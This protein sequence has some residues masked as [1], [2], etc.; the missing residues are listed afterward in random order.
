MYDLSTGQMLDTYDLL[1]ALSDKW[2]N[3]DTNTQRY[4]AQTIAGTNQ[5]NNFLA[6][7]NNF[8][9]AVEAT[10][11]GLESAGSA[12]RENARYMDGLDAKLNQLKSTFQ[13][14]SNNV[15]ESEVVKALLDLANGAL[16][17]LNTEV[18]QTI[19]QWGLLTGVLTGAITIFGSLAANIAKSV[20][21]LKGL[22]GLS[23]L[24]T[25]IKGGG[26]VAGAAGTA[27]GLGGIIGSIGAIAASAAP[28][29]AAIAAVA[30][31]GYAGY[32]I[33]RK[34]NP[35]VEELK[36]EVGEL[37]TQ[38]E[39]NQARLD[40]INKISYTG[41]TPEIEA[42]RKALEEE[43]A[44]L[45]ENIELKEK[46]IDTR[47]LED[48]IGDERFR[49]GQETY[50]IVLQNEQGN[51]TF[52]TSGTLDAIIEQLT[53][54]GRLGKEWYDV[55]DQMREGTYDFD[56]A[57]LHLKDELGDSIE[58][59]IT[60]ETGF[61]SFEDSLNA[62][63]DQYN[64]YYRQVQAGK[65]LTLEEQ[66][67]FTELTNKIEGAYNALS[68]IDPETEG[69]TDIMK[70]FV[71]IVGKDVLPNLDVLKSQVA[72]F[73]SEGEHANVV[74][75]K[76]L[77]GFTVTADEIAV[78][79][80]MFPD[81]KEKVGE[82]GEAFQN[83]TTSFRESIRAGDEW[84]IKTAENYIKTAEKGIESLEVLLRGNTILA[85]SYAE[86]FGYDSPEY[87]KQRE[88]QVQQLEELMAAR[89]TINALR[90]D[91]YIGS[92]QPDISLVGG[93]EGT[94]SASAQKTRLDLLKEQLEILDH[95]ADLAL[96]NGQDQ[97][98]IVNIY[99]Q[100]QQEIHALA[101]WYR[102]Q[103]YDDTSKEIRELQQLWW[104]YKDEIDDVLDDIV[105]K[106]KEAFEQIKEDAIAGLE[107][108]IDGLEDA[109]S[110][111]DAVISYV[112]N[113]AQ[114]QI[115][116]LNEQRNAI[117]QKYDD[118]I[119]K[120]EDQNDLLE[121][122][123]A[124]EERLDALARA[125]QTQVLVYK[126][127]RYQYLQD[128]D[129]VNQAQLELEEYERDQ[130]LEQEVA[131]LEEL[132]DNELAA[133]D[134]QIAK[135][136]DYKEAWENV[137][138]DYT[139][140]QNA[141]IAEQIVGKDLEKQTWDERWD[142]LNDFVNK[143]AQAMDELKRLQ[144]ELNDWQEKQY[145]DS[146]VNDGAF[147]GASAGGGGGGGGSSLGGAPVK[148]TPGTAWI[149]GVGT[150]PVEIENGKTQTEGLP[151]GTIVSTA[152]GDFEITGGSG[153]NY[154]SKKHASGTINA[155]GGLSL[156]GEKGPELRVL[157]SGDGI[158]PA[159]ITKNLWAWGETTPASVLRAMGDFSKSLAN[160]AYNFTIQNLNLPNVRD[161]QDFANVIT[162]N[163]W[164]QTVQFASK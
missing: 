112:T 56:T 49:V 7:M 133:I 55:V 162:S 72:G 47:S 118:E 97:Q 136:E 73:S 86:S 75:A 121:D 20:A 96:R 98:K 89:E 115:D 19:V 143:Y 110:D 2:Q 62:M 114:D 134:D 88:L 60:Y 113:L 117:S 91:M 28:I 77:G 59:L 138:Q 124:L 54:A 130:A 30:A 68:K 9:H 135:W 151:P 32:K 67:A 128:A 116:A 34:F 36:E 107:D 31:F 71:E 140:N 131:N 45:R 153:G 78:L 108:E 61:M 29:A 43:N 23:S 154:T 52:D 38:L 4:I 92:L 12:A 6:L 70:D 161:P 94:T 40:E 50:N 42:E 58:S 48:V 147:T 127:G 25:L 87:K 27:S 139:D 65:T 109:L 126:D 111:Y 80:K 148:G 149:P 11:V 144:E 137:V 141:L 22:G 46:Q 69:Y 160:K 76:L 99:K 24:V 95:Q 41:I 8:G 84:A 83:Y 93:D 164:I 51:L 100:A 74:L 157:N 120:L 1:S 156:V 63:I 81:L 21:A 102:D 132:R 142:N 155:P 16:Q 14:L 18:G 146:V 35:T 152:G 82:T 10:A 3:L 150:V 26:A 13:D 105:E 125:K 5:L 79:T 103:G 44:A 33:Y 101:E 129:A 37:N 123:I 159:D 163:M 119:A 122:Q 85:R 57:L 104:G 106:N 158:L 17:L 39:E 64:E 90:A 15:I 53:M 66:Q 145:E